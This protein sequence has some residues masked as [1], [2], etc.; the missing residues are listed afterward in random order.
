LP[1][2]LTEKTNI[3]SKSGYQCFFPTGPVSCHAPPPASPEKWTSI[4]WH[5][6][7]HDDIGGSDQLLIFFD[8]SAL[9]FGGSPW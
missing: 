5:L 1:A 8:V 7:L 6:A 9:P 4:L 2:N 3:C